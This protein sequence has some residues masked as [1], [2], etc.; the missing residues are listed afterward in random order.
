MKK[1]KM[2]LLSLLGLLGLLGIP[3]QHYGLFGFFGFFGFLSLFNLKND[4]FLQEN[5]SKASKPAFVVSLIGLSLTIV[6][7]PVLET[8]TVAMIGIA[9]TFF[10]QIFTFIFSL[11]MYEKR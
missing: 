8:I 2:V 3:T 4:E 9:V 6:L 11:M 10:L 5:V 1:N 7:V